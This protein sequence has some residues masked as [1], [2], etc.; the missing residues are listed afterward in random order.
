MIK[1][2]LLNNENCTSMLRKWLVLTLI[3]FTSINFVHANKHFNLFDSSKKN[4]NCVEPT[5]QPT[6]L[7]L[8]KS[9]IIINGTFTGSNPSSDKYLILRNTQGQT[10]NVP[11]NGNVYTVGQNNA[12]N[13]YVVSYGTSTTFQTHYNHGVRGNTEYTF[14]IYAVNSECSDG[15][16]YL[17]QNPLVESITNCPI[18][19]NGITAGA[20]TSDSFI[21]S[22]PLGENGNALPMNRILEVASDPNFTNMVTN[23]PFTLGINDLSLTITELNPNTKYYYR[24]KNTTSICESD[25]SSVGNIFTSCLPTGIFHETFDQVTGNVLPNCWSKITV[26]EGSY[27]PTVNV[28]TTYAN[29]APNGVTFYGNGADMT[30]L[31]NKAILVS[32]ELSNVG[33]GTHR[34]RFSAK[35]S[36]SGGTYDLQVVALS[37]NTADAQIELIGTITASELTPSYQEFSVNFNNYSGD[38]NYIGIRRIN[39]SSYSYLCVDD[40]IWEPIPTC[41]E[42]QSAVAS[43]P[44][45]DGATISWVDSLGLPVNG[46]E[47]LISSSNNIPSENEIFGT[48]TNSTIQVTG[49]SNGTYYVFVRRVCSNDDKSPWRQATFSTIPTTPAP[50]LEEFGSSTPSGWVTTGWSLGT[51]SGYP[52]NPGMNLHKNLYGTGAYSTGTFSTIPVGPL[53]TNNYEL[54]FDYRQGN[55]NSPYTPLTIWGNFTIEIST[56]FGQ[57]WN[58][59]GIV[60]DE[61]GEA[62]GAYIHKVFSL[63][64]YQSEYVKIRISA[65]RT[66]GDYYLSFDNFQIKQPVVTIENVIVV[67]ENNVEPEILSQNGTLQLLATVNPISENQEVIWS[68]VSGQDLATIN[69]N[70]IVTAVANGTVIVRATSVADQTKFDELTVTIEIEENQTE[71]CVPT[72]FYPSSAAEIVVN[73]ISLSGETVTWNVNPVEYDEAGYANYTNSEPVDLL[74]GNQYTLNFHS[75]WQDPHF[76]NVRAWVDYNNNFIFDEEEEIGYYNAGITPTGDGNF[77]FTVPQNTSPEIY[78]LRVMLQFPNSAPENLHACGTINSYGIAIDYNLQVIEG[79]IVQDDYCEVTVEFGVEPITLV[80]FSDLNNST[81]DTIDGTPAY[82]NFI[83]MVANVVKETSYNLTVK[84]N[85]NGNFEHDI[86]VFI[87]WNQDFIFDMDTEYYTASLLPS[88]GIDEVNVTIPILIPSDAIVGNTRMRIIKDQWNIYEAG[89]FDACTDAYYGQIEDYTIH[90]QDATAS[91][92]PFDKTAISIYPN[93]ST[94]IFNVSTEILLDRIEVYNVTGKR[95]LTSNRKEIDLTEVSS[96]VYFL[97]IFATNGTQNDY[98]VI[99]K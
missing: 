8:T 62:N 41:P 46:Y 22:W 28:T 58:Q 11:V 34:L 78:R 79:N 89:E 4:S 13:A 31:N 60:E 88:T 30:D 67:T 87:D 51:S 68:I 39:G 55:Y 40:L 25:Y 26:G 12:L 92:I 86:R 16:I 48:T 61:Q 59:I 50:W 84:G 45:I 90:V 5:A 99:K 70:G 73:N 2:R 91:L 71:Y 47:Y 44:T 9:G 15:P 56:D 23:S 1:N 74:A 76:V 98:K 27:V 72:F 64:G 81:S 49:L 95:I 7:V 24:G 83:S 85:T 6:N 52:G 53:N 77:E 32:P 21:L 97:R 54:S 80:N 17:V 69:Q 10:P 63:Q 38:A 36:S 94:G 18:S 96:G 57:T 93:P 33:Q 19:L 20:S 43:N 3:I 82:E 42:L 35:M 75:N 14:T 29:S 65:T 66:A 37:T